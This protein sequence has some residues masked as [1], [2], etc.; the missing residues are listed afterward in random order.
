MRRRNTSGRCRAPRTQRP[1]ASSRDKSEPHAQK[2]ARTWTDD[3]LKKL[4]ASP[5]ICSKHWVYEQYDTMV[6]TNTA[7]LP[8]ADAAVIRVKETRRAIAMCL[9]GNGRYVAVDA[10]EGAKLVVAEARAM[11]SVS[12]RSRSP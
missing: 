2:S 1:E 5:N 7:V 11:S 6:R 9:D 10:Y 8:G 4:L 12:G 3:A